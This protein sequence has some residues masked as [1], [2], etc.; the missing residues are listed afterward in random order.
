MAVHKTGESVAKLLGIDPDEVEHSVPANLRQRATEAIAPHDPFFETDPEVKEWI[1]EHIPSRHDILPYLASFFPFAAW[2]RRY[3]TRWLVGDIVAGITLGL[4]VV[5]QALSYALLANLSPEY[6]LYTS[7]TGASLYWLFGTSKDIAIG[8]TAVVSLLVGKTGDKVTAEHGDEF[9]REQIAKT[10]AFLAGCVL[11]LFGLFRLDWIIEFI[12]HV[13]ISAFVTGAAITITLSQVPTLLGIT[14]INSKGPA[15]EVFINVCKGLPRVH[16]DAAIGLS[17]LILLSL[18]KWACEHMAKRQPKRARM[19]NMLCSLRLTFTILLYTLISFLVHIGLTA[20]SSRFR[21]LGTIPR[22]FTRA[23]PPT[24]DT[25]LISAIAPDLPATIIVLIIEHIAIGKSFA[26]LNGYTVVPSQELVSIAFTN[27]TGP[28]VGAYASTGSFGGSAILSKAG[29]RTPLAGIFNGCILVLA[30]YALTSVLYYI[31]MASLS[32]LIIHAVV[33]LITSPEHV[34]HSWL[35]SPFDA[36]I[37]FCG[38]FVSIF[39]SLEDGIYTTVALSIAVM[40]V[41]VARTQARFM[42]KIDIHRHSQT[43]QKKMTAA[44]STP[45]P[46]S[47][48]SSSPLSRPVID[49][50][51]AFLPLDRHDG[52]NPALKVEAPMPGVFIYRFSEGFNYINQAQHMDHLISTI[53]SETRR[54]CQPVYA[55]PGDRPWNEP[56]PVLTTKLFQEDSGDNPE[57]KLPTL[58]AVVF[59]FSAVN[60]LDT[61]AA[62]GLAIVRDQLDEWAYPDPVEYHFA[63]V[64]NRWAR[65]ALAVAGFGRPSKYEFGLE[66]EWDPVY[67]VAE[68]GGLHWP[69][70]SSLSVSDSHENAM[71]GI[72]RAVATK[73]VAADIKTAHGSEQTLVGLAAANT[74]PSGLAAV[75]GIDRPNFHIDLAAAVES[76]LHSLDR[77]CGRPS[78][79]SRAGVLGLAI[80]SEGDD[81]T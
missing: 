47:S 51:P 49:V 77:R 8:A 64:T 15:Y 4:V 73:T 22:G 54:T 79:V 35:M 23:G 70:A 19:W 63:A 78:T 55:H 69:L 67:S 50:R 52:S 18:I 76:C 7:F 74:I 25:K 21:I 57:D 43:Q 9:S 27:L 48:S 61:G 42:G 62:E 40:L 11:L 37:Y 24:F 1:L 71:P 6:G 39:T 32:A 20:E 33:N 66:K 5:P 81:T 75:H 10:Q 65:R 72:P 16:L 68:K 36:L 2:I 14:G 34:Y 28:F 13:A 59:D 80:D 58:K 26:R 31:P 56:V 12:P 17:A 45:S 41:R 46:P 53:T 30:L 29:V 3:N 38:V 44:A 60:N